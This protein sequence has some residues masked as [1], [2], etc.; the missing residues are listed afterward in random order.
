MWGIAHT[1]WLL[2][3]VPVEISYAAL[4]RHE[5]GAWRGEHFDV[6]VSLGALGVRHGRFEARLVDMRYREYG[7]PLATDGDTTEG[8]SVT[9]FDVEV[10]TAS[11]TDPRLSVQA[12]AGL[13]MR[14]PLSRF[15]SD[16]GP[17]G[18]TSHSDGPLHGAPS[19]W[20]ELARGGVLVRGGTLLRVD[21]T[22]HAVDRGWLVAARAELPVRRRTRLT[23]DG[24]LARA[25]RVALGTLAPAGLPP[26]GARFW[27]ARAAGGVAHDLGR[28]RLD[29]RAWVERSDR[30]DPRWAAPAG[31]ELAWRYGLELGV[32][33]GASAAR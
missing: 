22:G 15:V 17:T 6:G 18:G 33:V 12:G 3:V 16:I 2:W 20:V 7:A 5:A 19:A 23:L 14:G 27:L 4:R 31:D 9:S 32:T 21:P 28:L 25:R 30:D 13:A 24:D 10:L 29:A 1:G 8:V 11:W 26:V